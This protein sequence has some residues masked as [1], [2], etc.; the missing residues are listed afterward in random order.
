MT[1]NTPLC[2][3]LLYAKGIVI[4][5]H[6]DHANRYVIGYYIWLMCTQKTRRYGC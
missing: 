5:I 6:D 4:I 3:Q 2:A 1:L